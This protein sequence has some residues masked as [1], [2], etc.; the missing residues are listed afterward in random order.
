M[1]ARTIIERNGG[2]VSASDLARVWGVSKTR[3]TVLTHRGSFPEPVGTVGGR[4]V[5]LAGEAQ[6]WREKQLND[7][8][9]G[10]S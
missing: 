5:W 7:H 6:D 9:E 1:N 10:T 8:R 2:L 4:P 3:L